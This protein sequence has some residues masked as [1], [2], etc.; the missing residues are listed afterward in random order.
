MSSSSTTSSASSDDSDNEPSDDDNEEEEQEAEPTTKMSPYH[1]KNYFNS[2]MGG[3]DLCVLFG[4]A[5][6]CHT[7]NLPDHKDPPFSKS[8][9][10]HSEVKP[11]S[12]TLKLEVVRR[13]KAYTPT[14]RQPRPS[15]WK[16]DKCIDYLMTNPIPTSEEA[17]LDWLESEL[18]KWK[19]IQVTINESQQ[20]ADDRILH[21]SWTSDIPFLRL[22]HTLVEDGIRSAF[23]KAYNA[24]TCE[25]LDGRNTAL[26]QDFYELAATQFN[27]GNWIPNSLVVP[28]LHEDFRSSKPLP[29]N[30]AP[31][32]A[33]QFKKKLNDNRYKMVKLISD[34]ERSG[35][36]AGMVND[37]ID[38]D[39]NSHRTTQQYEYEFLDGD[40]RK[41]FLCERPAHVL[42]LWHLAHKYGILRT[43]RQQLEGGSSVDGSNVP[44]VD[45]TRN[46][47]R[48]HSPES[49]ECSLSES[50]NITKNMEQ[51]ANSINGLVGVARQSQEM[52]QINML[53]RRREKLEE[54]IQTLDSACMELELNLLESTGTRKQVFERVFNKKK[55]ELDDKKTELQQIAHTIHNQEN[56]NTSTPNAMPSFICVDGSGSGR[57]AD[58]NNE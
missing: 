46:K 8:K 51:I 19:G 26:F 5:I 42:Y 3:K 44:K 55:A 21:R 1:A 45:T 18:D 24:K 28:D 38:E 58:N 31:I 36:G 56:K 37:M 25:E 47:K 16:I 7:R 49:R 12:A 53:H 41:S 10:Y 32:T 27:N 57:S 15:N 43:V 29:L 34:W 39:D 13:W 22:Y 48:K 23:G 35:A 6:G 54:A 17:D 11:D 20:N 2:T 50:V 52:Q 40:D 4:M 33:D 9:A 30:V 14:G